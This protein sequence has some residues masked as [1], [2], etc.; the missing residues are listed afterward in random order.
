MGK[1]SRNRKNKDGYL[2]GSKALMKKMIRESKPE[3]FVIDG[4]VVY[5]NPL[6]RLME[7]DIYKTT[8]GKEVTKEM[9]KQYETFLKQRYKHEQI[10]KQNDV[11]IEKVED[12]VQRD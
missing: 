2:P 10:A 11:D 4:K 6:K 5:Y 12:G 3:P 9:V 8:D 1:A 7:G